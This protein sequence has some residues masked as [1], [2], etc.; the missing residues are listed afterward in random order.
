MEKKEMKEIAKAIR[1]AILHTRMLARGLSPVD[2][3]PSGLMAALEDLVDSTKKLFRVSCRLECPQPILVHDNTVATQ[4]YRIVQEAIQNAVKHGRPTRVKVSL[5]K[6][7]A[8][9]TLTILDNGSGISTGTKFV[10]GMGLR[11]M[12]YRARAIGGNLTVKP[13]PRKGTKVECIFKSTL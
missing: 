10:H 3:E 2:V 9:I 12:H 11:I 8:T 6:S 7:G 13:A 1:E 5:A 4:L